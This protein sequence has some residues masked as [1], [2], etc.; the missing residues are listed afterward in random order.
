[1][2]KNE[3]CVDTVR[4]AIVETASTVK[5]ST[6]KCNCDDSL[7]TYNGVARENRRLTAQEEHS[8][9]TFLVNT[10]KNANIKFIGPYDT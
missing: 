1:M 6:T 7:W 10:F 9:S 3:I 8:Y 4:A 5:F 2:F